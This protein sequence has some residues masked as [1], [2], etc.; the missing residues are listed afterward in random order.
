M[1][2]ASKSDLILMK[3]H[4]LVIAAKSWVQK[5]KFKLLHHKRWKVKYIFL[6]NIYN[7]A[8]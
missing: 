5:I 2:N 1:E 6:Q 8:S 3:K 4:S 7:V